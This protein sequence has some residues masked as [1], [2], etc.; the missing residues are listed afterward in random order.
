MY[1]SCT[2][3]NKVFVFVFVFVFVRGTAPSWYSVRFWIGMLSTACPLEMLVGL[4]KK[5]SQLYILRKLSR[6][7]KWNRGV[8]M[9]GH[10]LPSVTGQLGPWPTR[11]NQLGTWTTRTQWTSAPIKLGSYQTRH[12]ASCTLRYWWCPTGQHQFNSVV[13]T[14][15]DE[16]QNLEYTRAELARRQ[17]GPQH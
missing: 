17:L 11:P 8:E 12:K 15:C 16:I 3:S 5:G 9:A 1:L 13:Y 6:D 2:W 4:K 14:Q 7:L 10:I